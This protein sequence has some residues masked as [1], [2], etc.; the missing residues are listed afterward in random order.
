MR[1]ERKIFW[2][3]FI[4]SNIILFLEGPKVEGS[5]EQS[6]TGEEKILYKREIEKEKVGLIK[7]FEGQDVI[8]DMGKDVYVT[9]G[10]EFKVY[11]KEKIVNLPLSDETVVVDEHYVGKIRVLEAQNDFSRCKII[12]VEPTDK[13]AIGDKIVNIPGTGYEDIIHQQEIDNKAKQIF[14]EA[15]RVSRYDK[16]SAVKLYNKVIKDFPASKYAAL[17]T[18]EIK[19]YD[20]IFNN[21]SY[22]FK[23]IFCLTRKASTD[24]SF[25]KDISID[26]EGNIWLL[27]LKRQR[28]E[29]YSQHGKFKFSLEKKNPANKE[30]MRKPFSVTTDQSGNIYIL[31]T[32]LKTVLK[33]YLEGR[34]IG[35]YGPTPKD[36]GRRLEQPV[37]LAV[38]NNGDIFILD[39]T[40]CCVYGYT[41]DNILWAS[42]GR[43]GSGDAEFIA[44]VAIDVD[45]D[46]NIY[47]LDKERHDIQ[48]FG[49]DLRFKRK[50]IEKGSWQPLE[51]SIFGNSI[52]VLDRE[53][54]LILE[55]DISESKIKK[56]FGTQ[57]F[58]HGKFV[59]PTGI[60][61]DN[62]GNIYV[63][64]GRSYSIQ[65]F[66]P[67]GIFLR[68]LK[69]E[70]IQEAVAIAVDGKDNLYVL[71]KGSRNYQKLD[72][73]GWSEQIVDLPTIKDSLGSDYHEIVSDFEGNTY[74]L[75]KKNCIVHKFSPSGEL[76]FS[77]GSKKIFNLP[78][79][80][81]IDRENN[82]YVLDAKDC[83][84]KKFDAK[85]NYLKS[86]GEKKQRRRGQEFGQFKKPIKISIDS[87]E[88]IYVLDEGNKEIYKFDCRTGDF[89][90][91]F[92]K[93]EGFMAPV[94]IAVDGLGCIYLADNKTNNNSTIY[95]YKKNGE[96][97][98]NI[99]IATDGEKIK[100]II[101][102]AVNGAGSLFVLD[103]STRIWE[104]EQ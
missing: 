70:Q 89:I 99:K 90:A 93:T 3:I 68:K 42:F 50:I 19:R 63:V 48:I 31:D 88:S 49:K 13:P 73:Y 10:M 41:R 57:G 64:D 28:I 91:S 103:D 12:Q 16:D 86:F 45:K 4:I 55:F 101:S 29:K 17:A 25:S 24:S 87:E 98:K 56:R 95:K 15:K 80:I 94:D 67:Q 100:K 78:I 58:G 75:D 14:F 102:I 59:D 47:I 77:F 26:P 53:K 22:I 52:Y 32:D 84:I 81:T 43:I 60:D 72:T 38:N 104:F 33:F 6:T 23:N 7:F 21:S 82:I 34:L 36:T 40:A 8:I 85:G 96:V 71:D 54:F 65:K 61:V 39:A 46:D 9:P 27:D 35:Y 2:V 74:I 30:I 69:N 37:D 11:R 83:S 62:E 97:L 76:I 92:G 79:D 51:M 44:P 18:D 1:K 66:S 5:P 20:R